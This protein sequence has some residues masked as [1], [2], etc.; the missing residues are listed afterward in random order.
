MKK[1]TL[2]IAAFFFAL[3]SAVALADPASE[4]L[5]S[6]DWVE[7]GKAYYEKNDHD[8]A[9]SAFTE[10][11]TLDPKN[12]NAYYFRGL[13]HAREEGHSELALADYKKA[14]ELNPEVAQYYRSRG[15]LYARIKEYSLA[16]IDYRK[17]TELAPQDDM[18]YYNRAINYDNSKQRRFA[19]ESYQAFLRYADPKLRATEIEFA[20]KR[21]SELSGEIYIHPPL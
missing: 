12:D 8:N 5:S 21:I 9:V 3:M 11:I 17:V 13:T 14:I 15:E 1:F 4:A 20:N 10:A 2:L 7:K 6:N 18:A 19:I 16:A